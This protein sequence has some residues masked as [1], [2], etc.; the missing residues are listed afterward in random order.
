MTGVEITY[1]WYRDTYSGV[2][3]ESAF[4]ANAGAG[5]RHV[6]WMCGGR[7]PADVLE[8]TAYKRAVCAA[9]DVF[10][11]Y[12]DGQVGGF[13]LG[14]FKVSRYE[15]SCVTGAQIASDVVM[16]ELAD[17]GLLFSGVR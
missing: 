11:E 13:S 16:R 7:E 5:M 12:G 17:T 10:A 1:E 9:T 3:P 15:R 2:L 6:A 4:E 8:E 14:D